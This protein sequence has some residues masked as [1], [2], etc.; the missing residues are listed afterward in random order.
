MMFSAYC[1]KLERG[2]HSK[3]RKQARW[4]PC[5]MGLFSTL[6]QRGRSEATVKEWSF[7]GYIHAIDPLACASVCNS[8]GAGRTKPGHSPN[9]AVGLQLRVDLGSQ[10]KQG[11]GAIWTL[12]TQSGHLMK[13]CQAWEHPHFHGL[14]VFN[15][16]HVLFNKVKA[17]WLCTIRK[18]SSLQSRST[19]WRRHWIC[20]PDRCHMLVHSQ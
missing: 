1:Q 16:G 3:L 14:L 10:I 20:R 4:W 2:R 12:V 7:A 6:Y 11:T 9:L 17:G 5:V 19:H 18:M 13:N 15:T 8:L